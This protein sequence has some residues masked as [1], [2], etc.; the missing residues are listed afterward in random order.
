M[1]VSALPSARTLGKARIDAPLSVVTIAWA[2]AA[3]TP[4][5]T[6]KPQRPERKALHFTVRISLLLSSR[7]RPIPHSLRSVTLTRCLAPAAS[8]PAEVARYILKIQDPC[9]GN[10]TLALRTAAQ[11]LFFALDEQDRD[12]RASHPGFPASILPLT[13]ALRSLFPSAV[14]QIR[15]ASSGENDLLAPGSRRRGWRCGCRR[16]GGCAR[17]RRS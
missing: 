16:R 14:K 1:M 9:Q 8:A 17:R 4:S 2:L 12:N 7:P 10:R 15:V 11:A 3:T 6:A 13:R 5:A